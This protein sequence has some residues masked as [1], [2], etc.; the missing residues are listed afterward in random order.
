MDKVVA[1]SGI[2]DGERTGRVDAKGFRGGV[3]DE[4]FDCG[5]EFGEGGHDAQESFGHMTE[6]SRRV[7][8][9]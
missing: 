2:W 1:F 8:R 3:E 5:R 4:G 7:N 9:G 6:A